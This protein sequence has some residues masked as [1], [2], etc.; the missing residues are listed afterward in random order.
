MGA[1]RERCDPGCAGA[2]CAGASLA[3]LRKK[4]RA[5]WP[6]DAGTVRAGLEGLDRFAA[7][8]A[9]VGRLRDALALL[10]GLAL[11]P[12][13]WEKDVLPLSGSRLL[14]D[15]LD[16]LCASRPG[17]LGG[18]RT[19]R[20]EDRARRAVLPRDAP[21]LGPPPAPADAPGGELHESL[22]E[23]LAR[24]AC[25]FSDLLVEFGESTP[26]NSARRSGAPRPS[27]R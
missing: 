10:Q 27:A 9:G 1:Q 11:A 8:G 25:F 13:V 4:V 3:V 19:S 14:A 23:R 17:G 21:A 20:C 22:R 6:G 5:G 16:E 12:E 26:D 7:A 2:A 24:G 18:R 15:W